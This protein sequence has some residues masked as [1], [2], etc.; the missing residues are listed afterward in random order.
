MESLGLNPSPRASLLGKYACLLLL[1]LDAKCALQP[2]SNQL[3]STWIRMAIQ[4]AVTSLGKRLEI[5]SPLLDLLLIFKWP[6]F[7]PIRMQGD[8]PFHSKSTNQ[9]APSSRPLLAIWK[10]LTPAAAVS[11]DSS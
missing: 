10:V 11:T 4:M 6:S 3:G 8:P 2:T 7:R 1:P 5:G 9:N